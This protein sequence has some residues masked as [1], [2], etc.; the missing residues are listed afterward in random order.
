MSDKILQALMQ[1][2]AIVANAE[3]LSSVGREIVELFLRQQISH[4]HVSKYLEVFDQQLAFFQGKARDGKAR[5]RVSV[6][7]V[8]VLRICTEINNELDQ[9]QKY[10]V[11]VR[12]LEFIY[13]SGSAPGEQ[14]MEFVNT[15]AEVF[16]IDR[17]NL[18]DCTDL[19]AP[20]PGLP[21]RGSFLYIDD[22]SG[23]KTTRAHRLSNDTLGG[24]LR[25]LYLRSGSLCFARYDGS[26]QLTL[27]GQA[28]PA[29]GASVL[30]P[31][32]VIRGTNIQPVYYNDV[33]RHFARGEDLAQIEFAVDEIDFFFPNGKQGLHPLSFRAST[34]NLVG[35]MGGSGAGKSTLLNLLNG[36]LPPHAGQ[37]TI[38]GVSVHRGRLPDGVIGYVPQDDLLIEELTVFQNLMFNTRLSYGGLE[39]AEAVKMVDAQLAALGLSET[40]DLPVGDVLHKTISGG[41]RKRL[42][43][44][45]ELIRKPSVLFVDE[46]T[47]GLSSM[48]SENVMDLLKQLSN[49]GKLVFVVIHQPSSDIY[50]LFDKLMILDTGGYPVYYGNPSDAIIYFK[51]RASY[52][53]ATEAECGTCGHINSEMVFSILESRVMDEFGHPTP[54]RKIS[55]SEWNAWFRDRFRPAP[56]KLTAAASLPPPAGGKPGR[57]RQL[58]IYFRRDVLSKLQNTQYL[59][60]NFLEAPL[61]AGVL[62][63]FLR[64]AGSPGQYVFSENLNLPAFMFISVIVALFMGL[65]V[66]A[67][68][69]IHD[70]K[71][72]VRESFL[73]LSRSSYLAAKCTVMFLISAIQTF[74]YVLIGNAI[75]GIHDMM[76]DYWLVLFSVSCFANLLGLNISSSFKSVVTIYILI[77]ILIIPQII[78]SGVMVKFDDL[79]PRVTSK[80]RVPLIGEVMAS[81]W[82]F[83]ALAV[84]QYS[85]NPYER[86]FFDMDRQMT[87]ELF[88]KDFRLITMQDQADSAL[89]YRTDRVQAQL[90]LLNAELAL[91]KTTFPVLTPGNFNARLHDS[92]SVHIDMERKSSIR[93]YNALRASR[94]SLSKALTAE[95]GGPVALTAMK[96]AFT[97]E[98][99]GDLVQNKGDFDAFLIHDNRIIQRFR[100]V[101]M[102]G[103]P[104][105]VRSP[106]YVSRKSVFG[107]YLPTYAVNTGIIWLMT[108]VLVVTLY[109][110]VLKKMMTGFP[111]LFAGLKRGN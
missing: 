93:K 76:P 49:E 58:G 94:D 23:E 86:M 99:L 24:R 110:D 25:V 50:K 17:E 13:A 57:L 52:A 85:S 62:G 37:V 15:V 72:L 26:R 32:S 78:L 8:K 66:S 97:N 30:S 5:K 54:E 20:G 89:R 109:F 3:R 53:D 47:S 31:G 21:D 16:H 111:G 36:N 92:I 101:Y 4:A 75:F 35:I 82:A 28:L 56:Q 84:H 70:R 42:N 98:G 51:T 46:P 83:E 19:V 102:D 29:S 91:E 104:G 33:I 45:L 103:P 38:N 1:L 7:S 96:N 40:R 10:I 74:T 68:E 73:N 14:E 90:D 106:M 88:N 11:L 108:I 80:A 107:K 79:N 2:F 61:L 27:N 22:G 18:Q 39:E 12:L 81:R 69:I 6:N 9:Q 44:A 63:F 64:Y 77:P 67:E 87:A 60:I 100:P 65:T 95:A 41:Q 34:G 43:I 48:D 59:L 105:T 71:I 55:P